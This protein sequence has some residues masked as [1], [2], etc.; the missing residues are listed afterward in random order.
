MAEVERRLLIG[1]LERAGG[2]AAQAAQALKLPR[3]TFYDRLSRH[4]LRPEDYKSP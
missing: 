2:R 1:A 3:K 4:A